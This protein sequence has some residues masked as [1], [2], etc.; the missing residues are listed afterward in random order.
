MRRSSVVR[1]PASEDARADAATSE[2]AAAVGTSA[3]GARTV[4]TTGLVGRSARRVSAGGSTGTL[5]S[6]RVTDRSPGVRR[7]RRVR[8][9]DSCVTSASAA[10]TDPVSA[11]LSSRRVTGMLPGCV[12]VWCP[13]VAVPEP[14]GSGTSRVSLPFSCRPVRARPEGRSTQHRKVHPLGRFVAGS[15]RSASAS[16]AGHGLGRYSRDR[17]PSTAGGPGEQ[18]SPGPPVTTCAGPVVDRDLRQVLSCSRWCSR[19][20][21]RRSTSP[22]A[23]S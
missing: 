14:V 4:G 17:R 19:I 9:A 8:G 11:R 18:R 5:R 15:T 13:S 10:V 20:P 12:M 16:R 3:A 1:V 2:G 7:S 22:R 23:A 6:R 21:R